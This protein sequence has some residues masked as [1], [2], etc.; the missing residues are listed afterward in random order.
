MAQRASHLAEQLFAVLGA[1]GQWNG[2]RRVHEAHELGEHQPRRHDLQ[3]IVVERV[4]GARDIER[5]VDH[6]AGGVLAAADREDVV[7][8]AHLHVVRLSCEDGDGAVLRLPPEAADGA[9][10]RDDVRMAA[11]AE[12]AL[13]LAICVHVGA[14]RG[15]LDAFDQAQAEQLQRNP[16]RDVP[17]TLGLVEVGLLERAA[18]RVRPALEREQAVYPAVA[19]AVRVE[20][21][22][23]LAKRPVR[24]FERRDV[25]V[26]PRR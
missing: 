13:G 23:H 8:D 3:R 5:L 24:R 4:L 25:F 22:S 10:V 1:G 12:G 11:D 9:V 18:R 14:N 16:E 7:A 21:E 15:V 26:P 2:L 6:V 17:F 20:L 19:R